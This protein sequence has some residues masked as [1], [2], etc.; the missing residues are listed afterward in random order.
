MREVVRYL[1]IVQ[2]SVKIYQLHGL[3]GNNLSSS[4]IEHL[5]VTVLGL[6]PS[7]QY[8]LI[9]TPPNFTVILP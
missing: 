1:A 5:N 3:W 4:T 7:F 2:D 6:H 9:M 8:I